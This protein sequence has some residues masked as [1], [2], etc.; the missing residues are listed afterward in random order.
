LT[1]SFLTAIAACLLAL[2][3]C[4]SSHAAAQY[5]LEAHPPVVFIAFDEF[6]TT[7]LV[8]AHGRI[9]AVRY[10]NFAALAQDGNWFPYATAPA[11]ETKRA[12]A[13]LLT[14]SFGGRARP[15]TYAANPRN[16]FT[17]LGRAYRVRADEEVTSMCPHRLC[18][19]ER[20]QN[21]RSVLHK[22]GG[23][24]PE[25]FE[26]WIRSIR[27]TQR[28]TLFFKHV[29]MPHGPWR[30]LPSGRQFA[31]HEP[32]PDWGHAFGV[33]WVTSQ[34]Y[35]RHLLQ[36]GYVDKL[37]GDAMR[38]LKAQGL[39]DRAL[40]VVTA[41]NG[42]S[43]GRIGN[44]HEVSRSN[45]GDIALTPLL[46][47]RPFAHDGSVIARHVR[48][49]DVLPTVASIAHVRP[50]RQLQGHSV[51]GGSA[52]LIPSATLVY[53]RSGRRFR[54]T[55]AGLRR[56]A[57]AAQRLKLRLFGAGDGRPGLY[58]IGP[59]RG[60][61]GDSPA[62][63]RPAPAGRTRAALDDGRAFASVR[64][65]SGFIPSYVTGRLTGAGAR[66]PR[67]V[68]I[69]VNDRIAATSPTFR[70]H[71][72]GPLYFAAL[73]PETAFHEGRNPVSAFALSGS[74]RRPRLTALSG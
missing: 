55:A 1:P 8:G 43:F 73:V 45:F 34:K 60:V 42:E 53:Q 10:P 16:L 47:K 27:A 54:L 15:P 25:R 46:I 21:K 59:Y 29:L 41:D 61:V 70:V 6:S 58:G 26:R 37:L 24:R 22:L 2:G 64:L 67:A 48:T 68:A 62:S 7:S 71:R 11:D 51:F 23:G 57:A 14:G 4:A 18:P 30:Y 72:G 52:R 17:L 65:S 19:H 39:Y 31:L 44:G 63:L 74:G 35:Q 20:Q 5:P 33:R 36:L 49:I 69:V 50:R 12:M 28:P 56:W 13:A 9:D 66:P 40:I 32:I 3:G 38:R